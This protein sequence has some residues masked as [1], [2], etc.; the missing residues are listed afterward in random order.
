MSRYPLVDGTKVAI[1][2]GD[3]AK[4]KCPECHRSNLQYLAYREKV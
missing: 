1:K 3:A 4:F 2:H